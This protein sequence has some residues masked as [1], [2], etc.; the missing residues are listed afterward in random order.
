MTVFICIHHLEHTLVSSLYAASLKIPTA[1]VWVVRVISGP[2]I[3]D[4]NATL[5]FALMRYI[6]ES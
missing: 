1:R 5:K 6:V 3:Y 2:P 4:T